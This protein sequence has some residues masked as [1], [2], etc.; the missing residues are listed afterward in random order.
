[1]ENKENPL[2]SKIQMPGRRFRLPSRGLFYIN[3]ELDENVIDGEVEVFSMTA[4]DEIS[5]RS[6]EFLFNGEAIDR[7][8]R[9]CIP[10]VKKPLKLLS[11]DVDFLL[12]AL[13]VVSYGDIL[14]IDLRCDE[15]QK[16]QD[17][18]NS[19]QEDNFLAEVADKAREQNIPFEIAINDEKVVERIA[20]IR[21]RKVP[22]HPYRI[23]LNGILTNQTVEIGKDEFEKYTAILS[24]GQQ[25]KLT[26]LKMDGAV[27]SYQFQNEDFSKDL[28]KA[29]DYIAF[30]MTSCILEVRTEHNGKTVAVK[31][32]EFISEWIKS[33]PIMLKNELSEAMNKQSD[34]GTD[35]TY[36]LECPDCGHKTNAS[37]LLNPITFFMPPSSREI[38]NV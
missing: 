22:K 28:S 33:L 32:P 26:P 2:L 31:E 25:L 10:E 6:P 29:E 15:C 8:F 35:F 7:V 23:N 24:N 13:R 16:H 18:L 36:T 3:G 27:L 38:L 30:V 4:V 9:R 34:W 37:T 20:A 14:D 17:K 19:D 12:T 21:G 11:K 5:L 1:M